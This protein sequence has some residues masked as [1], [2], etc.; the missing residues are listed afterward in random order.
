[1]INIPTTSVGNK[2][3]AVFS[4]FF[5]GHNAHVQCV[6][7]ARWYIAISLPTPTRSYGLRTGQTRANITD[8]SF[9]LLLV[10]A[11]QAARAS[12][13]SASASTL[14]AWRAGR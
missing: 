12:F 1:M 9:G 10:T 5:N 13:S 8:R 14:L 7:R 2:A 11:E 4:D 3:Q 6:P